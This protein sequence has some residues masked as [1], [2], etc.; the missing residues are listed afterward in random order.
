MTRSAKLGD[1]VMHRI[2]LA[3]L[4]YALA[5]ITVGL[6]ALLR[7]DLPAIWTD[8]PSAIAD[9]R[10]IAVGFALAT[11]A[12]GLGVAV[13]RTSKL[14]ALALAIV[15]GLW[16]AAVKLPL[17]VA[18]P[19]TEGSY[20]TTGVIAVPLAAALMLAAGPNSQP[21]FLVVCAR[22][23]FGFA[24]LAFG[25]SHFVYLDLT[26]PLVPHWLP[27]PVFWA[28]LTGAAY[29][30]AGIAII[31]GFRAGEAAVLVLVE[32]ACILVLV[33]PPVLLAGPP[34]AQ[35]LVEILNTLVLC[36]AAAVMASQYTDR[37]KVGQNR[38]EADGP[39]G[40]RTPS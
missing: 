33:W 38:S 20:Q 10:A 5:L 32:M 2:S 21:R 14:G 26:T 23:L 12:L 1:F 24:L 8:A 27:Q 34:S 28:Y 31:I 18:N 25:A 29:A 11:I 30:L 40:S 35:H 9:Q 15:L 4:V 7:G 39:A 36:A 16:L 17:I 13:D 22:W 37:R 6:I 3:R 19:L